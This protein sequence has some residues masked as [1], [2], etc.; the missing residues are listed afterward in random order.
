MLV[1]IAPDVY[2]PYVTT[3]AKGRKQLLLQ[4]LNAIYGTM[5][6]SLLYFGKFCSTLEKNGFAA[7]GY[8]PCVYNKMVEGKQ[9]TVLFHVD[10]CKLSHVLARVNDALIEILQKEYENIFEDGSGEMKVHRG[11]VHECL[12]M[13]LDFSE[14]GLVKVSMPKYIEECLTSFDKMM[15]NCKGTKSSAAPRDLFEIDDEA[16]KLPKLKR[17][18]FHSLA[19]G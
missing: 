6:A 9:Q 17:E 18:Q 7:N 19:G 16:E 2:K 8:D 14:K 5:I 1:D 11:K 12:G 13:T 4:C 3:D 10:D 15:P